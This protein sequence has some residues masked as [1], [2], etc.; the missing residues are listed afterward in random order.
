MP[1]STVAK[2]TFRKRGQWP[3]LLSSGLQVGTATGSGGVLIGGSATVAYGG[4]GQVLSDVVVEWDFDNDGDFDAP[5]ED[6][7][8]FV[9]GAET[10][11]GRDWPSL[12]TGKAAPGKFK[13][14]LNNT[15]DRFSYFNVDSPLNA[16]SMSLKT[17]RKLRVRTASAVAADP[18]VLAKD[19]FNRADG[20]LGT[21]ETGL[22]WSDPTAHDF[23]IA[24]FR[25][26]ASDDNFTHIGVLD[27]SATDY[28]AQ[29]AV[30]T[31]GNA[32]NK[33]GLVYRYQD[34]TNYSLAYVD[35]SMGTFSL[36]DVVAGVTTTVASM[37]AEV[38]GGIIVGVLVEGA[39]VTGYLEG[40]PL[41]TGV[42]IQTDEAEVGIYA[43][44]ATG[45]DDVELDNF[46]VWDMVPSEVEG[47]LWTGDV[48]EL[49][50]S[51][52]AGPLKR[53]ELSGEGWLS[54]LATQTVTPP[55][56]VTG[57]NTGLLV[58]SVL[59][60]AGLL[61]PPGPI[62]EGDV[63]TGIFAASADTA[64]SIA[65]DVEETELGF[66][67][68]TNEGPIGFDNR[69]A[70]DTAVSVVTFSDLPGAQFGYHGIE[71][72]DWRREVFNRVVAG[73]SPFTVGVEAVLYTDPGPYALTSGD[74][75]Q[76]LAT[77][78]GLV[79]EW[80]GHTR[81]VSIAGTP[82][83][84]SAT[85]KTDTATAT[86]DV[87]MPATVAAGDLLIIFFVAFGTD[88][89][90]NNAPAGWDKMVSDGGGYLYKIAD[91]TEDGT[92]VTLTATGA[93]VV[94]ASHVYRIL[95]A[96]WYGDLADGVAIGSYA[97]GTSVSPN[98]PTVSPGWGSI[99]TLWISTF[100]DFN[101]NTSLSSNPSGY[102]AGSYTEVNGAFSTAV[103]YARKVSTAS[104]ENAG[105]F[106]IAASAGWV[107]RTIAIRGP[108][109]TTP[110]ASSSPSGF[111]GRFT[112]AYNSGVGGTTQSHTNIEVTG[113]PIVEGSEVTV[114]VNDTDSQDDHNAIRTYRNPANLFANTT[115]AT[116]YANLVIA[117]YADDRPILA[118]RFWAVKSAAY[119][120]QALRRRVSDRIT[121]VAENNAGLGISQDFFIESI[122]HKF[123][124]GTRLWET[125]WE[126]SPA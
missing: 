1:N 105:A 125:T 59:G 96:D 35:V 5:E 11:A 100:A 26:V 28:Y 20:A 112:I 61:N 108:I 91:G 106:T 65:R 25:A 75:Q 27:V 88:V 57:R 21:S 46:S 54:K 7:T 55:T 38:Y 69:S 113:L 23:L 18:A 111:S 97:T 30:A 126:L 43:Y 63:T 114:E 115:D 66:L 50:A 117:R 98:A 4:G 2:T 53:V 29:V 3:F 24:D 64:I 87:V 31:P 48:S 62:D 12:L 99:P 22:V 109:T 33:A 107:A 90:D 56:S 37:N 76:L 95:A 83:F 102:T 104:S 121:L 94:W 89:W 9:L 47:I 44:H 15:D 123:S 42:A 93:S 19:R 52:S 77:Y 110:V 70:R 78:S 86:H 71:P 58:G 51:V 120:A 124:K 122:S 116:T 82:A 67:F 79:S 14:T 60:M 101:T 72:M 80:T 36:V 81:D 32:S 13:A 16:G 8:E 74:S 84:T 17:G 41:L 119:R 118:I 39:V 40:V 45:E 92:N 34:T 10:F 49:V 6:I 73:V 68:E 103:C 85:T